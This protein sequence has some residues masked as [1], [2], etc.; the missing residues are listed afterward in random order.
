[1]STPELLDNLRRRGVRLE[2]HGDRLKVDA[3]T[4]TLT[5]E[6]KA[7]LAEH[8]PEILAVLSARC[9]ESIPNADVVDSWEWIEERAAI[10][11]FDGGLTRDEAG[12][13]AF[14]L[15]FNRFIGVTGE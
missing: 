9:G 7:A 4:G 8:K 12:H 11:E 15:W 2:V 10:L 1:M 13:R 3:P 14:E 6:I 5:A